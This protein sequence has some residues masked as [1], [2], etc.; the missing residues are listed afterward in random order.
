[1]HRRIFGASLSYARRKMAAALL[2][3]RAVSREKAYSTEQV[4]GMLLQHLVQCA[5]RFLGTA[6]EG[7]VSYSPATHRH[8]FFAR[9]LPVA[10]RVLPSRS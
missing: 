5:T 4:S 2:N 1:M 7:A 6:V 9:N 3:L 8:I 10:E